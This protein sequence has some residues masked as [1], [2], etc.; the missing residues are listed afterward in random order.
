M[1]GS[2][3]ADIIIIMY[4]YINIMRS[5]IDWMAHSQDLMQ[6]RFSSRIYITDWI[7]TRFLFAGH[8]L[9][10]TSLSVCHV[11]LLSSLRHQA[12]SFSPAA[13]ACSQLGAFDHFLSP[14]YTLI[15]FLPFVA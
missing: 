7:E 1:Q 6:M 3:I 11:T 4:Y 8:H 12:A 15:S 9:S 2:H 13:N 14:E 10:V 5:F